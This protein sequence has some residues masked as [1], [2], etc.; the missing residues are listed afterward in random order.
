MNLAKKKCIP[1]EQKNLKSFTRKQAKEYINSLDNWVLEKSAKK[2]SRT[3]LFPDFISLMKFVNRVAK[4]VEKEG[5]HPDISI[6]Y[7]KLVLDLWTHSIKGLS[8][9]DFI[10]ASKINL[11]FNK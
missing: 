11:L 6:F 7:N 5:H 3:I 10:V 4:L 2:I 8:E 1:C 9:N